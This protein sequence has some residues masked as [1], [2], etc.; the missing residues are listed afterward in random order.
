MKSIKHIIGTTIY[1][2]SLLCITSCV[3]N[4][5]YKREPIEVGE[6]IAKGALEQIEQ[7]NE[8]FKDLFYL[9]LYLST[10]NVSKREE[11]Q[12][13]Y[14][15]DYAKIEMSGDTCKLR[16]NNY[17]CLNVITHNRRLS[18]EGGW[19]AIEEYSVK[20]NIAPTESGYKA[21]FEKLSA[22]LMGGSATGHAEFNIEDMR[23]S[24]ED[25]LELRYDGT[26]H[27]VSNEYNRDDKPATLD[28][29][30]SEP[31]TFVEDKGLM[32]GVIDIVFRDEYY[33]TIDEVQVSLCEYPSDYHYM[34]I[35]YLD[36]HLRT[37]YYYN[38][39]Y[40]R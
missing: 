26:I 17:R 5:P 23:T 1:I 13:L 28:I 14:L 8:T 33:E 9:D 11:I 3:T 39:W 31:I 35:Y 7:A 4:Q 20:L 32:Y 2:S 6:Y 25:N 19:D 12:A 10:D 34:T 30:I 24:I 36:Y 22:R 29:T 15:S 18:D 37:E 21:K 16:P 40:R 27:S 38:Y